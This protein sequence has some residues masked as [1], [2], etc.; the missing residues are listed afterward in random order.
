[1]PRERRRRRTRRTSTR[2]SA[3]SEASG[4]QSAPTPKS[5]P[6]AE[7][8]RSWW[9]PRLSVFTAGF[10]GL[11]LGSLLA[12]SNDF[13]GVVLVIAAIGFALGLS[14]VLGTWIR[15]RRLRA[16]RGRDGSGSG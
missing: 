3:S 7:R 5:D 8:P 12:S 4:A 10:G 11:W 16:K 13:A 1:M 15:V 2:A 9:Q 6:K 14:R